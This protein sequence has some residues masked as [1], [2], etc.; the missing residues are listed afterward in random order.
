MITKF[1]DTDKFWLALNAYHEARGEPAEGIRAVM[2]VVLNRAEKRRQSVFQVVTAPKQFSWTIGDAWPIIKNNDALAL[3]YALLPQV[4]A[5]RQ[6]AAETGRLPVGGADH[7]YAP[8]G[9]P[10]GKAPYWAASMKFIEQIGGHRFY[11]DKP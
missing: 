10:G 11:V 8:K 5:E 9:M 1:T 3:I 6:K 2:H 7:Y 4:E